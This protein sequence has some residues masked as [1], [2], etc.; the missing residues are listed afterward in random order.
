MRRTRIFAREAREGTTR[1]P[2]RRSRLA[3]SGQRP[4]KAPA[5]PLRDRS[6]MG[7]L[8]FPPFRRATAIAA[9]ALRA[10]RPLREPAG[11]RALETAL[12]TAWRRVWPQRGRRACRNPRA[13]GP[14]ML[15]L[16]GGQAPAR[17]NRSLSPRPANRIE[18]LRSARLSRAGAKPAW[19]WLW[20][21]PS[22]RPKN[23][24]ASARCRHRLLCAAPPWALPATAFSTQARSPRF[25]PARP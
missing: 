9:A 2:D 11:M 3:D 20:A 10:R 16:A 13:L 5:P 4:S 21:A 15:A 14:L 8:F 7:L 12:E 1:H 25:A 19:R 17:E 23:K 18:H 22:R 24:K 6:S